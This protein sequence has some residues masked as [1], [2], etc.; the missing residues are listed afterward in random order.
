MNL[1]AILASY[2]PHRFV[3]AELATHQ[4]IRRYD[5]TVYALFVMPLGYS[6]D[7]VKVRKYV[8]WRSI[9]C[10]LVWSHPD[11]GGH[12][13]L[14]A[15]YLRVGRVDYVHNTSEKTLR[16]LHFRPSNLSVFNAQTTAE[17][18]RWR[19]PVIVHPPVDPR[20][21]PQAE[22]EAII[23]LNASKLKGGEVFAAVAEASHR[24]AYMIKG[25]HGKQVDMPDSVQM[26]GTQ[27]PNQ[28][29]EFLTRA[30]VMLM[31]T[32]F[33]AYGMAGLEA[34]ASGVPVVASDLP[35]VREALGEAAVYVKPDDVDGFVKAVERFDDDDFHAEMVTKS[36]ARAQECWERTQQELEFLDDTLRRRGLY[37]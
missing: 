33:E 32:K 12:A 10:D 34:L 6:Y 19:D 3:G 35:G 16:N 28:I 29:P 20:G 15:Q 8:D 13:G 7:G 2:P 24:P 4:V 26:V 1:A 9:E 22:G 11:L 18:A 27:L 37:L 17:A 14:V 36:L 21:R 31:P 30:R 25:G 5:P 23:G